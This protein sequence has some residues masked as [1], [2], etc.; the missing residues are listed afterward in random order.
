MKSSKKK[1]K[2][3][4]TLSLIGITTMI[5]AVNLS[6]CLFEESEGDNFD[7]DLSKFFGIWQPTVYAQGVHRSLIFRQNG[8]F[9]FMFS[10]MPMRLI[11]IVTAS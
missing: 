8:T 9:T 4:I 11:L 6:G 2:Q 7:N 5:L 3:L 1:N 10:K